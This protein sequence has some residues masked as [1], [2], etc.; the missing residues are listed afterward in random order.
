[1]LHTVQYSKGIVSSFITSLSL[2]CHIMIDAEHHVFD[3]SQNAE[4]ISVVFHA[5]KSPV[6][7]VYL[8]PSSTIANSAKA[9]FL[10]LIQTFSLKHTPPPN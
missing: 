4:P 9:V 8:Y 6:T 7:L 5:F 10:I 3:L 1:M 2:L